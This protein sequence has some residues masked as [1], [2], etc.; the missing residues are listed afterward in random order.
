MF[1]GVSFPAPLFL[2]TF[3]V[4]IIANVCS[5]NN[6]SLENLRPFLRCTNSAS[7]VNR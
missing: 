1:I 4:P 6:S 5:A 3:H 2:F 7:N